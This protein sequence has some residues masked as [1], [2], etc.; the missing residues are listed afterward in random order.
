MSNELNL[1][2]LVEGLA[3]AIDIAERKPLLHA[4]NVTNLALKIGD[5]LGLNNEVKDTLYFASL[6]HDIAFTSQ[7]KMCPLCETFVEFNMSQQIP[8]LIRADRVIHSS[9]RTCESQDTC[10]NIPILG[11]ILN[12]VKA[13][14]NMRIRYNN[15]WQ[16]KSN[17][18]DLVKLQRGKK[19]SAQISDLVLALLRDRQF[20][21]RLFE[22]DTC[23]MENSYH[24]QNY[25]IMT[26]NMLEVIGKAFAN[27]IDYKTPYTANHSKDVAEY[28][29]MI[30]RSIGL[31]EESRKSVYIASLLHDLG[32][33]AVP[34]NI[35]LKPGALTIEEFDI[36]KNH[37]YYTAF[38]L[39]KIPG[40]EQI[41][42]IASSHHEKLNGSGYFV[43]ASNDELCI[44]S[45]IICIADIYAALVADR[46][47]RKGMQA[48]EAL[49]VMDGMAEKREIDK[50]ILKHL[51]EQYQEYSIKEEIS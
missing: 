21:L 27:F 15:F 7:N 39:N 10:E 23:G 4:H 26:D 33:V 9:N 19:Y 14:E 51:K 37:V 34:D 12:I 16:C 5:K 30:S 50:E 11:Q 45:R 25:K 24:P 29:D 46:P 32:K 22:I 31:N 17:V 28:A 36:I 49:K 41:N 1:V 13:I 40:F 47:Y 20:C 18:E 8:A 48:E 43:G 42:K 35:L 2:S 44:E 3:L 38:L 6:L